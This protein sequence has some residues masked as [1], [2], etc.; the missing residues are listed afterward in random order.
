MKLSTTL[1]IGIGVLIMIAIS[2]AAQL[3]APGPIDLTW[4]TIDSGGGTSSGGTFTMSATIGQPEAGATMSGGA[5]TMA[6]G[7]WPGVTLPCA[8]DVT[9]GGVVNIDDLVMVITGWGAC[10]SPCPP[11]CPADANNDCLVNI[12]D[13]VLVITKWGACP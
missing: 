9:G 10:P 7:F 5:F 4:S 8:G 1:S 3:V 12:D 13:L 2:A 11:Q 6:G